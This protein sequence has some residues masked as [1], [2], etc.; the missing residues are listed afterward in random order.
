MGWKGRGLW[1]FPPL[2]G[3]KSHHRGFTLMSSSNPNCL[4]K[5][6]FPNAITTAAFSPWRRRVITVFFSKVYQ[7]HI[8]KLNEKVNR[9]QHQAYRNVINNACSLFVNICDFLTPNLLYHFSCPEFF[10][11][12][13]PSLLH[14]SGESLKA[15]G[16][17]RVNGWA[18][19]YPNTPSSW[20]SFEMKYFL[21][22][23]LWKSLSICSA[24]FFFH[25]VVICHLPTG[26]IPIQGLFLFSGKT[27]VQNTFLFVSS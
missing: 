27:R 3:H 13:L 19:H 2:I 24:F 12:L 18:W 5:A 1:S 10:Q 21:L 11:R 4:P 8:N 7:P 9:K 15:P 16:H 23:W 17:R 25:F 22:F 14:V 6:L 20:A 26:N